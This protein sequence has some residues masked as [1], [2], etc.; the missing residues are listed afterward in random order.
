MNITLEMLSAELVQFHTSPPM[1]KPVVWKKFSLPLYLSLSNGVLG[2][3]CIFSVWWLGLKFET[4]S[5]K[6]KITFIDH[7]QTS[8]ICVVS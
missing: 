7:T 5:L 2:N 8:D 3:K 6:I 1:A 4:A